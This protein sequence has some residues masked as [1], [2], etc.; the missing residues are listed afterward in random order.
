MPDFHA[1]VGRGW[2]HLSVLRGDMQEALSKLP[3]KQRQ[4]IELAFYGGLT[5]HEIAS[6]M[7]ES[8]GTI[9]SRL[10]LGLAKLRDAANAWFDGS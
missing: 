5:S 4:A 10:R 1:A 6:R 8:V 3:A 7:N 9:R 2:E